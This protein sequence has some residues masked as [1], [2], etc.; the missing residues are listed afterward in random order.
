MYVCLCLSA[1]LHIKEK[2]RGWGHLSHQVTDTE[3]LKW[4]ASCLYIY[5]Y[6]S[7][8]CLETTCSYGS[9]VTM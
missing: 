4:I 9:T 7:A 3:M 8:Q 1:C 2:E 6:I 5:I